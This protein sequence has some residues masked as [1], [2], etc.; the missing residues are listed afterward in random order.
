MRISSLLWPALLVAIA[1]AA[2]LVSGFSLS[3]WAIFVPAVF[4]FYPETLTS[5]LLVL[6]MGAFAYAMPQ[7][8]ALLSATSLLMLPALSLLMN[9]LRHLHVKLLLGS[10]M[11][12]MLTGIMALQSEA[13]LAGS[14]WVFTV[15]LLGLVV[16][17]GALQQWRSY[18]PPRQ[19]AWLLLP[20]LAVLLGWPTALWCVSVVA[21]IWLL[22]WIGLTPRFASSRPIALHVLPCVPFLVITLV[23]PSQLTMSLLVAWATMLAAIWIGEYLFLEEPDD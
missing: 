11:I 16:T 9:P 23:T 15:L 17:W 6:A 18:M 21:V 8:P 5:W 13:K 2:S 20:V 7:L 1:A 10:V 4:F 19:S 3:S 14:P 12:A 22:Q